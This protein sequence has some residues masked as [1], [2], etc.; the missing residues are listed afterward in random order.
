[1]MPRGKKG[2]TLVETIVTAT[3]FA[4]LAAGV[5]VSFLSGVKLWQRAKDIDFSEYDAILTFEKT[6]RELRQSSDIS[7]IGFEGDANRVSFPTLI[8][9]TIFKV[10]YRFDH[11]EKAMMRGEVSQEDILSGKEE[12]NY[13]ERKVLLLEG[14][15]LSYFFF[16]PELEVYAWKETWTV[17]EGI[18]SAIKFNTQINGEEFNKRVFIPIS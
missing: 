6:T 16:D 4:I 17:P 8:G 12:D 2:F 15:S 14:L 11:E 18:F 9:N 5:S 1:M 7:S 3:I 13:I 10:T